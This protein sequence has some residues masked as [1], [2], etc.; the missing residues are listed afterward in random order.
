MFTRWA[1]CRKE[2]AMISG[3]T[4]CNCKQGGKNYYAYGVPSI[5]C[6]FGGSNFRNSP[7]CSEYCE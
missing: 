7:I 1:S 6:S 5:G 4:Q 3:T 2:R